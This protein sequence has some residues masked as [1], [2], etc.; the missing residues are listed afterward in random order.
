[1]QCNRLVIIG[2]KDHTQVCR[3]GT[4]LQML[5][6][7]WS[8]CMCVGSWHMGEWCKNYSQDAI[9]GQTRVGQRN[10][11]WGSDPT[12]GMVTFKGRHISK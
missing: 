7:I 9:L 2:H 8:L 10:L 5:H 11:R 4:L 3:C 12:T 1:M 6:T